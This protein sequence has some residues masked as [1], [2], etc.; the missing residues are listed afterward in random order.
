MGVDKWSEIWNIEIGVE[1]VPGRKVDVTEYSY[2]KIKLFMCG[3]GND[4]KII[5]RRDIKILYTYNS[6]AE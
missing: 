5:L 2:W 3:Y 6:A 4:Y 1:W